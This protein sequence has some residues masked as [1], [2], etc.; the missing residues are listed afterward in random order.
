MASDGSRAQYFSEKA[1]QAREIAAGT[2][3]RI[4]RGEYEAIAEQY[5]RLS[6]QA[7]SGLVSP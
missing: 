1:R 4:L 6:A 2:R 3:N 7:G 5:E